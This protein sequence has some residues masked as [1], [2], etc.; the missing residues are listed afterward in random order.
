MPDYR[1][2][3]TTRGRTMAGA[4]ALWRATGMTDSDFNKPIIAIANSYTQFVPGHVHLK[5]MGDL[6]AGEIAKAGGV[7]KEFNTIAVDDGIAMGHGGM[8]YSLPSREIIAD[9]VEYMVNAHCADALV[10]ISNCDKITPGMLMAALRLNIP[11]IFVSGGPMEAGKVKWNDQERHVD[12]VDAMIAGADD[13]VDQQGVDDMERSACPT[14]GSC[15]GMF[16]ANS[17][18]CLTEALGLSLPGNGTTLAT[19]SDRERLFREAGS[20]IVGLAKQYYEQDNEHVLPRAI[21]NFEAFENAMCLD[22]SMGGST[23]TVL[24]LLAAA[25]EAEVDFTM[26]DIDRLSRIVP[27]L[28]KVA[29]ATPEYHVEDVHRAGGVFA[30]LG[31]LDRCG[32]INRDCKTVHSSTMQA[33][34]A[35]WDISLTQDE[36]RHKFFKAAPGGIPTQTPFSQSR[37][38]D[39]LDLDR[40][41]GCI[42]EQKHAYSQDGGLAVLYGNIAEDGCIVKTAGVDESCLTFSGPARIFESQED[43]VEGILKHKVVKGD[44][45][46]IRY[47]GPKGGPGMQEMLYPTTYLKSKGLGKDCALITDGRFSGGTSGLS[48]GHISPEAATG[49]AIGLIEEG[50]TINIDIPKRSIELAVDKATL[51]TRREAMDAKGST[52]WKPDRERVVSKALWAYAALATSAATGGVRDVEQ[53]K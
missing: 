13:N 8:L 46:I 39:T 44:V 51:K 52:G 47:E 11:A 5:D 41:K 33:A 17:M 45:V 22:I 7:S 50:D 20:I 31:E 27:N 18:N 19:H 25:H 26:E 42:R 40:E 1:S 24:H 32:L 37:R 21:A 4:R 12:L 34:I 36:K 30:I 9:S 23:N 29:P 6:V 43:A 48:I 28:C 49:G 2:W 15:S 14:C 10:C 3:T 38:F 53:L 35:M 16:T